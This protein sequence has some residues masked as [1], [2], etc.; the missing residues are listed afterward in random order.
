MPARTPLPTTTTTTGPVP[1]Q[2]DFLLNK[3]IRQAWGAADAFVT[4]DCGAVSNMLGRLEPAPGHT[5]LAATPVSASCCRPSP[6]APVP[7][8]PRKPPRERRVPGA[9]LARAPWA[10]A[11]C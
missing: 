4:T 10:R 7:P 8:P 1:T 6:R 9:S 5:R 3:M 2:S 11:V